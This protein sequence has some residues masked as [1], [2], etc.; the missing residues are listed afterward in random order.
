M[1]RA[2]DYN[3]NISHD[4]LTSF[5]SGKHGKASFSLPAIRKAKEIQ[6]FLLG[7]TPVAKSPSFLITKDDSTI[8]HVC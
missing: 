7:K 3:E 8:F 4:Y 5:T 6:D 1:L 2:H